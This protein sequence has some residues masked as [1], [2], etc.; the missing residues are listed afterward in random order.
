MIKKGKVKNN[1]NKIIIISICAIVILVLIILFTIQ[2]FGDK[3]VIKGDTIVLDYTGYLDNGTIFDTSIKE[4][5]DE[6]G[7]NKPSYQSLS[8]V[9]GEGKVISGFDDA[10]LGMHKG[11]KKRF[12]LTPDQAYGEVSPQAIL[13]QDL[14]FQ[15]DR[16]FYTNITIFENTFNQSPEI[17]QVLT[18]P[19]IAWKKF[20]VVEFNETQVKLEAL[21]DIGQEISTPEVQEWN[22]TVVDKTNDSIILKHNPEIGQRVRLVNSIGRVTAVNN[23]SFTI[24]ANHHL[25]GKNLTFEI[26]IKEITKL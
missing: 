5:G 18:H 22:I 20:K 4:I 12:T 15:L 6:A 1:K 13:T 11:E 3:V 8:F 16:Y 25:A 23:T 14:T 7:M 21:F 10:V 19:Q 26:E 24:D 17:N 2:L 9:V